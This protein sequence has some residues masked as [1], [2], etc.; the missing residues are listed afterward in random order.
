MARPLDGI[1]VLDVA[2]FLAAPFC[3]VILADFGAEV[4]KI[5]QPGEGDPLRRFGTP[6]E[7]GDTLVWLSEARNKKYVTLDLRSS[8]G[9]R[10]FRELVAQSDVVLE[11]FRPGTMEKWGLGYEELRKVNP[12][13]VMLRVSAYGQSG[14]KRDIPGFARV[15]HAFSG[16]AYLAG[17]AGRPPVVPGS[18]SIGDYVAGLW[19]AIGVL[20]A[21][22]TAEAGGAGQ[23]VD[24]GLY[25][26]IFRLM[27][28]LM[29]AYHKFGFV[30]ERMGAEVAYVV[31]H[32]HWQCG[33]GK[34]I[35]IAC[36][37][38]RMFERLAQV[39]GKPDLA[40]SAEFATNGARV[41]NRVKLN[42]IIAS[43]AAQLTREAAIMACNEGQVPCGPLYSIDEIATDP[44]YLARQ[45]FA[46]MDTPRVDRLVLPTQPL[47]LS[48]T[49]AR[50][51]H[52]GGALGQDTEQV[53]AELL[54]MSHEEL[55][56]L[57]DNG[58]I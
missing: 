42:A 52:P 32:G 4:I 5:E 20:L 10:L 19:G 30:R 25:E 11:N 43:W 57:R 40:M 7:C 41:A 8:D 22:R 2:T 29:P 56:R 23:V 12:R 44:Q 37:S 16:L 21:L 45:N 48:E 27:D 33:D 55:A 13:I 26:G 34:W 28:E 38:E 15:A 49:S 54:S 14:P 39:M 24:I 1:R 47:R 17:E 3:G 58:V 6:T 53:F 18:T 46:H 35:A 50:L 51:D 9:S 31:P 36:S